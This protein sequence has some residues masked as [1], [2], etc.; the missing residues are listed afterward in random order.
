MSRPLLQEEAQRLPEWAPTLVGPDDSAEKLDRKT[1]ELELADMVICPSRFV[2]DSLPPRI[3]ERTQC[4]ISE[5]GSPSVSG[6]CTASRAGDEGRRLRVLFAGAMTQR[7]GLADVF[8]AMKL[9]GRADVDLIVMGAPLAPMAFYRQQFPHFTYEAPRPRE[10][11][12]ALMR[13]CDVLV[14][15]SIVEGRALVQQEALSCGLPIIVTANAGGADLVDEGRTG[16]LV[17]IRSPEKIASALDTLAERRADLPEMRRAA[18]AKAAEYRWSD[19]GTR[20]LEAIDLMTNVKTAK[21][22]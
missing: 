21:P 15:P 1:R 8:A 11:V 13:R 20:I 9:L 5:F 19:Y 7:K 12:L 6:D 10:E 17:P 16:F 22:V 3:R 18:Q 2:H 14:L 4:V